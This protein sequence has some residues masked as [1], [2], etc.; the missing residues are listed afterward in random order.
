MTDFELA[1]FVTGLIGGLALG[2]LALLMSRR[3]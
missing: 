2:L 3:G 1:P